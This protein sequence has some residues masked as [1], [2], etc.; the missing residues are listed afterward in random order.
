[1]T[2]TTLATSALT[3]TTE[4][5]TD[6][7]DEEWVEQMQYAFIP[8]WQAARDSRTPE[9]YLMRQGFVND[10]TFL[11]LTWR[12]NPSPALQR[13]MI[14]CAISWPGHHSTHPAAIIGVLPY[15]THVRDIFRMLGQQMVHS[16]DLVRALVAHPLCTEEVLAHAL[17]QPLLGPT[18]ECFTVAAQ[19][20]SFVPY[21]L[22]LRGWNDEDTALVDLVAPRNYGSPREGASEIGTFAQAVA[23]LFP[24]AVRP[25]AAVVAC[26]F[27]GS[28]GELRDSVL[29]A[30]CQAPADR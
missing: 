10:N 11:A 28:L 9:S 5:S 3:A 17:T 12:P 7:T 6:L 20:G 14:S 23:D 27:T 30:T 15:V 22:N 26:Q 13:W 4:T 18:Q 21:V 2:V 16:P 29:A 24:P 25:T 19:A 8:T 1:M